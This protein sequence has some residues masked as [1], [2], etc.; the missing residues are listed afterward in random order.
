MNVQGCRN[1]LRSVNGKFLPPPLDSTIARAKKRQFRDSS[2]CLVI[3]KCETVCHYH[4][5]LNW[6]RNVEP[7]FD[8]NCLRIPTDVNEML[9]TVHVHQ[10]FGT[11]YTQANWQFECKQFD[12]LYKNQK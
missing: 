8:P 2:G 10:R 5:S 12:L 7:S 3:P 9:L 11:L 6:I 1:S 4:C